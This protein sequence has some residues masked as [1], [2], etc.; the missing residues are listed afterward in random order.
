[1]SRLNASEALGNPDWPLLNPLRN[2]LDSD[3][4]GLDGLTQWQVTAT[5]YFGGRTGNHNI[6]YPSNPGAGLC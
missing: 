6:K 5:L 2:T 1:M 4:K 3:R